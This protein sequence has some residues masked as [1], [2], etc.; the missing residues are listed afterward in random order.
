MMLQRSKPVTIVIVN[1]AGDGCAPSP[2][3]RRDA[4]ARCCPNAASAAGAASASAASPA[5]SLKR[6][7]ILGRF[8]H[9]GDIG[10]LLERSAL[11]IGKDGPAVS[12]RHGVYGL[13]GNVRA[14]GVTEDGK[15][16][17]HGAIGGA[18]LKRTGKTEHQSKS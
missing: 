15:G 10:L 5:Y 11:A 7:H 9:I 8:D 6:A 16:E 17:P 13:H 2:A 12:R 4:A 1:V 14:D 3:L 18:G